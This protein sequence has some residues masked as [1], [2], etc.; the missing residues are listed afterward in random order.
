MGG[1]FPA[2]GVL[3][4]RG[5]GTVAKGIRGRSFCIKMTQV[6]LFL[7]I[8]VIEQYFIGHRV[9]KGN[10]LGLTQS[11]PVAMPPALKKEEK[12]KTIKGKEGTLQRR[13]QAKGESEIRVWL[14]AEDRVIRYLREVCEYIRL[15]ERPNGFRFR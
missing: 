9:D 4:Y 14:T 8:R 3:L 7:V 12:E 6:F 1:Q 2:P 5:Y 10:I 11:H 15:P 13:C